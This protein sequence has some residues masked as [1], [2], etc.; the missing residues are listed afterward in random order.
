MPDDF[1]NGGFDLNML[2]QNTNSNDPNLNGQI[3]NNPNMYNGV[4]NNTNSFVQN[5]YNQNTF[6]PNQANV[7]NQNFVNQPTSVQNVNNNGE[8]EYI[9]YCS[10]CGEPM[11]N[12][13]RYCLK[14]GNLNPDHPANQNY[15][16]ILKKQ[17]KK[18]FNVTSG[19]FSV[20][21]NNT[22]SKVT[23]TIGISSDPGGFN[24]C[25]FLNF[26]V[27]LVLAFAVLLYYFFVND[28]DIVGL[29]SSRAGYILLIITGV[30]FYS[31]SWE[32]I[33]IKMNKP[34]WSSLV[35][36]Y[37]FYL[38]ADALY[39][40]KKNYKTLAL[41]PVVGQIYSIYLLYKMGSA[42]K[43]SG[44]SMVLLFPIMI[45]KVAFGGSS[46]NN[47][48]Y[49]SNTNSSEKEFKKKRLFL[50]FSVVFAILSIGSVGYTSFVKLGG[51]VGDVN[52]NYLLKVSNIVV[53]ETVE[54]VKSKNYRCDF[55]LTN[56]YFYYE[57]VADYFEIPFAIFHDPVSA[58]VRVENTGVVDEYNYYISVTDGTYGFAEIPIGQLGNGIVVEYK[59][60]ANVYNNRNS[61][62]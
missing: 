44:I 53:E 36:I 11:K 56:F 18:G 58:Y 60:L 38:A 25:F 16:K 54:K 10:R 57:N 30:F 49:I 17:K 41:I 43:V 12:T 31:Y 7:N 13:S 29:I 19:L 8:P 15:S 45:P 3:Q 6:L 37:N 40:G 59:Q 2:N 50:T 32:L 35:P 22:G 1:N 42:F 48:R 26:C 33:F 21:N 61:C 46:F 62:Y 34:W 23:E 9:I 28:Q 5:S 4:S 51:E 14:C 27:Y 39:N 24:F 55:E 52:E 47:I 20:V